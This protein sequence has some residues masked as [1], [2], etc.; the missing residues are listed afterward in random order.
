MYISGFPQDK[1]IEGPTEN[2]LIVE[3]ENSG[4]ILEIPFCSY[5]FEFLKTQLR[6]NTEANRE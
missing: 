2:F 1:Y 6:N 3:D 4:Q 5:G